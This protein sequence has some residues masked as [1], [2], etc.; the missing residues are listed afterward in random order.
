MHH[1]LGIQSKIIA[2]VNHTAL[3]QCQLELVQYV[4]TTE[5]H[6]SRS[7]VLFAKAQVSLPR[8]CRQFLEAT[9]LQQT[10]M[11]RGATGCVLE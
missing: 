6:V 2:L 7:A 5:M 11:G 10:R 8:E 4:G 1:M 9:I 3:R